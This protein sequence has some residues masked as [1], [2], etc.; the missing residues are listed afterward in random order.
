MLALFSV[1]GQLFLFQVETLTTQSE[2]TNALLPR[3]TLLIDLL[4]GLLGWASLAPKISHRSPAIGPLILLSSNEIRTALSGQPQLKAE[5]K[6]I[7]N[8]WN[9]PIST[10]YFVLAAEPYYSAAISLI[11]NI[12]TIESMQPIRIFIV[13]D[14]HVVRMGLQAM[15]RG[16]PDLLVVG[17]AA[18]AE[19]ALRL[20]QGLEVDILLTD[21]RLPDTS[22]VSLLMQ[23]AATRPEIRTAVLTNYHSDE[24]VFNV[25]KAGAKAYVLKSAPMEEILEAIRAVQSGSRWIP[26]HIA[27]QLAD[28]VSRTQL[29]TREAEILQLIARGKRNRDIAE[30]LCIS[31]NTVRNHILN[32]L[33]KLGTTHR[34]EAVALAIQQGLV[35]LEEN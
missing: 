23:L 7:V 4:S 33:Q 19:D 30:L 24:D 26:S 2:G 21:L 18:S 12:G 8:A 14:H 16:E 13:E 27:K 9:L 3:T 5:R 20:L 25:V 15:L 35:R 10:G 17:I 22:G 6:G 29:S 34:T 11:I 31:E 32:L 28:R 1:L